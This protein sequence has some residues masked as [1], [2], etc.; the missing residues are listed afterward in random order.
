[1]V[2]ILDD[3]NYRID[4]RRPDFFKNRTVKNALVM[5]TVMAINTVW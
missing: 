2:R 5:M 1:M 4:F 3:C